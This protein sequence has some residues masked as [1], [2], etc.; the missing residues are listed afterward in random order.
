MAFNRRKFLK[1]AA[2][3]GVGTP[4]GLLA[5]AAVEAGWITVEEQDV[6]IA[7]LPEEFHGFRIALL[8]DLHHGR[9]TGLP[10]IEAVIER[11]NALNADM[12]CVTGDLVHGSAS[13]FTPCVQAL[14]SLKAPHGVYAVPGN[15]DNWTGPANVQLTF[16]RAKVPLL[17]NGGEWIRKESARIR[18]AGVDDLWTGRQNLPA[19]LWTSRPDDVCILMSHNPDYAE[20]LTDPRVKLILSGHTH[21]G[22]VVFPFIGAP[23]VPSNY[24]QK[25][26]RGLV[27]APAT[28]VY[29]SRGV[30][31]VTPPLRFCSPP[32][33]SV[34][35][36]VKPAEI[37]V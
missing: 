19:A 13:Y 11:A 37:A 9:F 23:R 10:Y 5:Y 7:N 21:G 27:Q 36:L 14:S 30:G 3:L 2:I 8:T 31:T 25:Y 26:L 34:L 22:Q 20:T 6:Q 18:I 4:C 16:Y 35:R 17:V 28:Q 12:I 15:H 29:V 1:Y 24:G 32:E 33:I